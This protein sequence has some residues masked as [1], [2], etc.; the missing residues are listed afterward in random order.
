MFQLNSIQNNR[1]LDLN[2]DKFNLGILSAVGGTVITNIRGLASGNARIDGN[3][4]NLDINGRLYLIESGLNIPYLNTDFVF[5][6]NSIVDVTRN[7][8]ILRNVTME[9]TA[10]NTKGNLNG[11]IQHKNFGDW[12]LDL[13]IN[14]QNLLALNTKDSE[15]SAFYGTAFINGYATIS[16]PTNSLNIDVNAQSNKGTN[17]KIPVNDSESIDSK[18]YIHFLSP[19]E[20]YNLQK[21][22]A[23]TRNY[24]G[25][26]LN[27][28]LD[29]TR[30]A[31]I[32]VILDRDSGHGM[33][34]VGL[35]TLNLA[36]NTLGKFNMVGDFYVINGKYNFKY[37][38][39]IDKSFDVKKGGTIVWSGDPLRADL[40]L[41]AVYKTL[42]NPGVLIENASFNKKVPVEVTIGIKGNL[43]NPE[44][45]FDIDFPTVSSVLKSEIQTKLDDKDVRQKQALILL[46]TGS[47]LSADGIN[48]TSIVSNNLFEKASSLFDDLFQ[49]KDSKLKFGLGY[50]VADKTPT[51]QNNAA[52]RVDVNISTQLN[53]RITINGKVGVPVGGVNESAIVGNLEVEYRVNE[54]GTLNLRVFNRENEINY[55]GEGGV[56]YTQG[57]GMS[58][59]V[60]FDTFKEFVNKVF[61]KHQL[62][63]EKDSNENDIPDSTVKPDIINLK[64]DENLLKDQ[65][66]KANKDVVPNDND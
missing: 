17:I 13:K 16:G 60:D 56:G 24:G 42:A 58:Y 30:D 34:G 64:D 31:E 18:S 45:D 25:L 47:F 23:E 62:G 44:P 46:G 41:E 48:N 1:D 5:E 15:D 57:I 32:E 3:V 39:L 19:K 4:K 12:K 11:S 28:D 36:I 37:G 22:V 20:K 63:T 51:G 54:D 7:K 43:S 35:G 50:N 59:E 21:G 2:F 9:D 27:F 10:F 29:I 61:K 65:E 53:E 66:P 49:D 6:K 38:G 26:D 14:S 33:K 8:F 55:I 52:G 40:N